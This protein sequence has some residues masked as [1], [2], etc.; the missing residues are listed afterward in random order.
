MKFRAISTHIHLQC[1]VSF[2]P[3]AVSLFKGKQITDI[4]LQDFFFEFWMDLTRCDTDLFFFRISVFRRE[5][6]CFLNSLYTDNVYKKNI[7]FEISVD[8]YF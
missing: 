3:Q 5:F 8:R 1:A 2:Q 4:F 6:L 7:C